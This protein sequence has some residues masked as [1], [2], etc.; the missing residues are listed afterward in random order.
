MKIDRDNIII[1]PECDDVEDGIQFPF[2]LSIKA[3]WWLI[4]INMLK[5]KV[6]FN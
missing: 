4:L 3:I 5:K 2:S 1:F 6:L